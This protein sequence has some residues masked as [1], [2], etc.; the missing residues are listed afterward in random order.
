MER[1]RQSKSM[2]GGNI[3]DLYLYKAKKYHY[4]CQ[5]KLKQMMREGKAIPTGYEQ[6]LQ[7]FSPN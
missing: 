1:S 5:A 6:Y 2:H 7:P 4:K 3:E